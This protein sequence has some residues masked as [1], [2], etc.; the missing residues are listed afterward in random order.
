MAR[1]PEEIVEEQRERRAE[2]DAL[3]VKLRAALDRLSL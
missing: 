2:A 3:R 1:A